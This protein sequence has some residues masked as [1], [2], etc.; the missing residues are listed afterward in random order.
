[1]PVSELK[2]I[3]KRKIKVVTGEYNRFGY[4]VFLF[5]NG[6]CVD[7]LYHAGN[8]PLDSQ[9]VLPLTHARR[10]S[11]RDLRQWCINEVQDEKVK[12]KAI[13]GGVQRVGDD[14]L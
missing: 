10:V 13:N 7:E 4:T 2:K 9:Q 11:L 8:H 6:V 5:I 1:M 3:A 12:R 14:N